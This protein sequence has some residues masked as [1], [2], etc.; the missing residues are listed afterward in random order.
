MEIGPLFIKMFWTLKSQERPRAAQ[1]LSVPA[2]SARKEGIFLPLVLAVLKMPN[3][4]ARRRLVATNVNRSLRRSP[5][6]RRKWC[7]SQ[8]SWTSALLA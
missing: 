8:A 5:C 7:A 4:K 2:C 1:I 3:P 6:S